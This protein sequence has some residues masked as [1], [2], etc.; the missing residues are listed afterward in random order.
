[1]LFYEVKNIQIRTFWSILF[2]NRL[3]ARYGNT[4]IRCLTFNNFV[5]NLYIPVCADQR[6]CTSSNHTLY[7]HDCLKL[8]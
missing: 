1:M 4:N 2:V 3:H 8:R 7:A 5:Y 6:K